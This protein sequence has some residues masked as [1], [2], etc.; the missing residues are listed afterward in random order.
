MFLFFNIHLS[1]DQELEELATLSSLSSLSSL[2]PFS[3]LASESE[4]DDEDTCRLA[5]TGAWEDEVA[6]A[7]GLDPLALPEALALAVAVAS[8]TFE[9]F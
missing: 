7:A 1:A 5:E 8:L 4:L 6:E 9:T 2:S 3:E